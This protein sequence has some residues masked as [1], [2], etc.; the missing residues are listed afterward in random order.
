L[1]FIVIG[2]LL[3]TAAIAA[4]TIRLFL[5][6]KAAVEI[7]PE[8]DSEIYPEYMPMGG[9]ALMGDQLLNLAEIISSNPD[10]PDESED[11]PA[12]IIDKGKSDFVPKVNEAAIFDPLCNFKIGPAYA[13]DCQRAI[14]ESDATWAVACIDID[15]FRYINSLK[16]MQIGDTVLKHF[17]FCLR[18]MFPEGS[19]I[20]RIAADHFSVCFPIGDSSML[21]HYAEEM[22]LACEKIRNEIGS[23]GVIR[24]CMGVCMTDS[25]ISVAQL[26]GDSS[27]TSA[28]GFS[29]DYD[30][31]FYKANLARQCLKVSKFE[32][33]SQYDDTMA[34]TFL[35]GESA[36]ENFTENQY[37]EEITPYFQPQS[38]ITKSRIVAAQALLRWTFEE[39]AGNKERNVNPEL[40]RMPSGAS[41][42]IYQVCLSISRWRKSG[43]DIMPVF[44]YL[45][46]GELF[47]EDIDEFIVKCVT[48]FQIE[49]Q[50]LTLVIDIS[51][52]LIAPNIAK[53]Q[54]QKLRDIG[55][56]TA[57]DGYIYGQGR[58][59]ML[60]G[61]PIDYVKIPRELTAGV[62][63]HADR[64]AFLMG[65]QNR[66]FRIGMKPVYEGIDETAQMN[67]IGALG[68][69]LVEGR[70]AGRPIVGEDFGRVLKEFVAK[71]RVIGDN[72]VILDKD[73]L[74]R[75]DYHV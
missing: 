8:E 64:N 24:A 55:A 72:T 10:E 35:Y 5:M 16:G 12:I 52:F 28:S 30:V 17:A 59:E 42:M 54:V 65:F 13:V 46:P 7:P 4:Y 68:G 37:D 56:K 67:A 22:K 25:D 44:V 66:I 36:L 9:D 20:T 21:D 51:A 71:Q 53:V 38:D 39:L 41:R 63:R 73:E 75:G 69:V 34:T 70:Y 61:L 19:L 32:T 74:Q 26:S 27:G 15:R 45:P 47:K 14:M 48:E 18:A 6:E 1:L 62:E 58:M 11:L 33:V 40:G 3:A 43:K 60:E 2:I 50:T 29:R 49:P 23:K 57:V 31:M